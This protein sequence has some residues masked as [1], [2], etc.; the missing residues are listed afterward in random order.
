MDE[1]LAARGKIAL[2][3]AVGEGLLSPSPALR[4]K[5]DTCLLCGACAAHCPSLVATCDL[6]LAARA[7]LAERWGPP[8]F[9]RCFLRV[10]ASPLPAALRRAFPTGPASRGSASAGSAGEGGAV[11]YFPGCFW[12][13][14]RPRLVEATR[15]VLSACG[16]RVG[17]PALACCGMPHRVH[18]QVEMARAL[19]RQN[20]AALEGYAAVVT[21][22]ASC[23]AALKGYGEL[24]ADDPLYRER[25]QRFS[26]R[27]YDICEFLVKNGFPRPQGKVPLRVTYHDPCH[28]ARGQGIKEEP[29]R[30]L[31]SLPGLELVEMK[32]ADTCC[33]GAGLFS[34]T[35][36]RLSEGVGAEKVANLLA[37]G[38]SAVA[39]G[40]PSCLR[41]IAVLLRRRRLRTSIFHPVE[42]LARGLSL[43]RASRRAASPGLIG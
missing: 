34:L 2:W 18:G 23:G 31:A 6:F 16:Y 20:I 10:L 39:T 42:L 32:D 21:D 38:A 33:G 26:S 40:C 41:Q 1:S 35:H 13:W 28:L 43:T 29:R 7:R 27:V 15:A 14:G 37:T 19:A 30:L 17:Y 8:L 3:E 25:G 36:P 24:L 12:N 22:C 9:V 11:A 5:L 4:A